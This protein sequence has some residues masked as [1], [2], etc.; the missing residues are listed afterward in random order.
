MYFLPFIKLTSYYI[1]I[2]QA[3]NSKAVLWDL[4]EPHQPWYYQTDRPLPHSY[5]W[6]VGN[7]HHHISTMW[8]LIWNTKPLSKPKTPYSGSLYCECRKVD[9]HVARI[10]LKP[11]CP[12][13]MTIASWRFFAMTNWKSNPYSDRFTAN[14]NENNCIIIHIGD[15]THE[16]SMSRQLCMSF[17]LCLLFTRFCLLTAYN[18]S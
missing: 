3:N 9:G 18:H 15:S 10:H 11:C 2:Y 5:S 16:N 12:W 7:Q 1:N 13:P 6:P 14:T 17:Q 8:S 4:L